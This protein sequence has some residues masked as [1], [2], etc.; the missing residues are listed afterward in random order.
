MY[1]GFVD[2]GTLCII[3]VMVYLM[4]LKRIS[5]ITDS[6][7]LKLRLGRFRMGYP[8]TFQLVSVVMLMQAWSAAYMIS[9]YA[10]GALGLDNIGYYS[11]V[12]LLLVV[13]VIIVADA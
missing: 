9:P 6:R 5:S 13:P 1:G 8:L 4:Y 3:S 2:G 11:L 12:L 7:A 10:S